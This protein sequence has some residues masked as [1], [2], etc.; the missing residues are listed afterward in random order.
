MS[1]F[2]TTRLAGKAPA[3]PLTPPSALSPTMPVV[4]P[5]QAWWAAPAF[6]QPVQPMS[7]MPVVQDVQTVPGGDVRN[8]M[9]LVVDPRSTKAQSARFTD[10]CPSCGSGNYR[11]GMGSN[12]MTRCYDCGYNPRF[13]QQGSGIPSDAS[14]AATPSKQVST[15]NNFNPHQIIGHI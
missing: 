7:Q 14:A 10:T 4:Q 3:A 15:A 8:M 9:A 1:D 2:W 11:G 12:E 13:T 6:A 5:G